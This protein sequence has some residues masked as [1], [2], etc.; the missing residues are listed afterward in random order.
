MKTHFNFATADLNA[1]VSFYSS[2]FKA[3]PAKVRPDYALFIVDDP[4][5]ELALDA[6]AEVRPTTDAHYGIYVES[7]SDVNDA[8]DRLTAA[9]LPTAVEREETCCYAN[10]TKVWAT[11]PDGRRWEIY[12]VHEETQERDDPSCCAESV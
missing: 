8:I 2:L 9:G 10:Q 3:R 6:R 7:S 4:G 11:D 12:T 5:I 1:S